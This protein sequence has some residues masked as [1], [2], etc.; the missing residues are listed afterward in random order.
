MRLIAL[1][2]VSA[3]SH[4]FSTGRVLQNPPVFCLYLS[5]VLQHSD[6]DKEIPRRIQATR[7]VNVGPLA[8][9]S[10]EKIAVLAHV[11]FLLRAE[12]ARCAV[13]VGTRDTVGPRRRSL[14]LL[15]G[16]VHEIRTAPYKL[17]QLIGPGPV[18]CQQTSLVSSHGKVVHHEGTCRGLVGV[19]VER[20]VLVWFQD[21]LDIF[22]E[23]SYLVCHC[24]D[25]LGLVWRKMRQV[26]R[27]FCMLDLARLS[28]RVLVDRCNVHLTSLLPRSPYMCKR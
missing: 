6:I 3:Y 17:L 20:T 18:I 16:K 19:R 15:P 25:E 27:P 23:I 8:L 26:L 9:V 22:V 10:C 14:L 5:S 24:S 13:A 4:S 21:T 11:V 1:Q 2:R 7:E 12:T 28:A